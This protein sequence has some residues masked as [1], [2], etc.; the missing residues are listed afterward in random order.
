MAKINNI[1]LQNNQ[2]ITTEQ[3]DQ[4]R[5]DN[6]LMSP[7]SPND[8]LRSSHIV[9]FN[10]LDPDKAREVVIADGKHTPLFNDF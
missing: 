9:E 3:E 1:R 7:S 6:Y 2:G 10:D 4:I 8:F 5:Y